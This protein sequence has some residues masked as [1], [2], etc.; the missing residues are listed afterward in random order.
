MGQV[1]F[2]LKKVKKRR[3]MMKNMRV[4]LKSVV[5]IPKRKEKNK[6]QIKKKDLKLLQ[7]IMGKNRLL[8][9]KKSIELFSIALKLGIV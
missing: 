2:A 9:L 3:K 4:N 7:L 5:K 6:S 1:I 8:C